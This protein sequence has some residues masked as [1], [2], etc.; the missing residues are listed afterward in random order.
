MRVKDYEHRPQLTNLFD[1]IYKN[2]KPA[3]REL[4]TR[5]ESY[6]PKPYGEYRTYPQDWIMYEKACSQEKLMFFK[7]LKD[8]VNHMELDYEYR[9]NGRPSAFYGDIIKSLCIRS[10]SNYSSWR[11]ESEL[12]IAHAMGVIETV[13]KRST[14]NK[15]LQD[16]NISVH[17]HTLL[18]IIAEPLSEI[19]L[20]FAADA[21][22]ISNAY[23][24]TAWRNIRHTKGEV[25]KHKEYTKLHIIC[26]TK[27]NCI[28]AAKITKGVMHE[29][30]H[31]KSL[32]HETAALFNI[33]EVSAD[34]GYLSK[35]NVKEIVKVGAAPFIWGKN[36]VAIPR[37]AHSPW[38]GMLRM[39]KRHKL[40]FGQHYHRRSNVES[41][42]AALK[43]KYG[44]FCRSKLLSS[45]EN[46]ILAK[47]VCYNSAVLGEALL[48]YDLKK[49]FMASL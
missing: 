20:Y 5:L 3:K 28:C 32:L 7:I 43:R 23:G 35:D 41:T 48:S 16:P 8:A 36:N 26:G 33:T 10:Y 25:S 11:A 2:V 47:I 29:S 40:Y 1:Q 27:T 24:N 21:T 13:Y 15:Y 31:F 9:G 46:E 4:Q 38:G 14:L 39:W 17:L 42:F 12:K 22:G 45:Q 44:D 30:P 37:Y 19:E 34:A 18:K 49:G 6:E